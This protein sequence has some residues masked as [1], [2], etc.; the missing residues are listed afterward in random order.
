MKLNDVRY[1][2]KTARPAANKTIPIEDDIPSP[3]LQ[4][5]KSLLIDLESDFN[6]CHKK[7]IDGLKNESIKI[8]KEKCLSIKK[9][10]TFT[11]IVNHIENKDTSMLSNNHSSN[12]TSFHED[13]T[14]LT[15]RNVFVPTIYNSPIKINTYDIYKDNMIKSARKPRNS[16]LNLS[17]IEKDKNSLIKLYKCPLDN[18]KEEKKEK[19]KKKRP[20]DFTI[21]L[22]KC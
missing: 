2:S 6:S 14:L 5:D 1:F 19:E 13:K 18:L 12:S 17:P 16:N 3:L 11:D 20:K 10:I 4:S 7:L 21:T 9:K 22:K 8:L 15:E